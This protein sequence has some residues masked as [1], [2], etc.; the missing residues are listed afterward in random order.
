MYEEMEMA[1][2]KKTPEQ[3]VEKQIRAAQNAVQDYV[4]GVQAVTVAPNSIAAQK[5][6]K[7]Q[8]ATQE[9]VSSGRYQ[10][11]NEAVT[12]QDWKGP[13]VEK[14]QARYA[15]GVAAAKA[16]LIKFQREYGPVRDGI[17]DAVRAMPNDTFDQRMARMEKNARDLHNSPYKAKK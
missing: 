3:I 10:R 7:Y 11:A 17:A 15:Q 4:A 6:S 13:T 9:A 1:K 16:K 8:N 12:L 14:G 2:A 5:A